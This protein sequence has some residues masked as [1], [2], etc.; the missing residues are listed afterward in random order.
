[1]EEAE[2]LR[3]FIRYV[4]NYLLGPDHEQNQKARL[5]SPIKAV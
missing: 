5:R 3:N 1:V 2:R 4:D